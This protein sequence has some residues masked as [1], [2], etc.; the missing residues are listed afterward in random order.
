MLHAAAAG[1]MSA[2]VVAVLPGDDFLEG[3]PASRICNSVDDIREALEA[4]TRLK[5]CEAWVST[6]VVGCCL[7]LGAAYNKCAS[8]ECRAAAVNAVTMSSGLSEGRHP[9][10]R[11]MAAG[12]Q[13]EPAS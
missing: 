8:Q 7:G 6:T 4:A 11:P 3:P 10:W 9:C 13:P 5:V 12:R 2:R 1:N